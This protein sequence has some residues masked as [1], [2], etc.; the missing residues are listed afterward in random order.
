MLEGRE[1]KGDPLL[2]QAEGRP[3]RSHRRQEERD[4]GL[5]PATTREGTLRGQPGP[6]RGSQTSGMSQSS[7]EEV[8]PQLLLFFAFLKLK[9]L[10]TV[11]I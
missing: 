9:I 3:Q 8:N 5:Q 4:H 1:L 7:T 2:V 10:I 6:L 11:Y